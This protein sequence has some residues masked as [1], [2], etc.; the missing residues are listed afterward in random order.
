M[1]LRTISHTGWETKSSYCPCSEDFASAGLPETLKM[2][3]T[4][5]HSSRMR[6]GEQIAAHLIVTRRSASQGSRRTFKQEDVWTGAG[7]LI[8]VMASSY[9]TSH[10]TLT[11][12]TACM[13]GFIPVAC[14]YLY[15]TP[16]A[17]SRS[18]VRP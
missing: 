15:P 6:S 2:S 3:N 8:S 14:L 13:S 16:Y 10:K 1:W 4:Y 9:G 7:L 18:H 17:R 5:P 12:T 11:S